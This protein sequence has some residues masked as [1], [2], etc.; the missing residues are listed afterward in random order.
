MMISSL[1]LPRLDSLT[2]EHDSLVHQHSKVPRK[3]TAKTLPSHTGH[4]D[5][6]L[7]RDLRH[8]QAESFEGLIVSA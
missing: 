5:L 2:W 8:K 1:P 7:S 4:D 6:S 3:I